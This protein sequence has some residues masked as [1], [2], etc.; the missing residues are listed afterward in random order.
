MHSCTQFNTSFEE[1]LNNVHKP[2][3]LVHEMRALFN[4]KKPEHKEDFSCTKFMKLSHGAQQILQQDNAGG[5]SVLSEVLSFEVLHRMFGAQF[6][7]GEMELQYFPMGS[8]RTDM[9]VRLNDTRVGVSVT[10][11]MNFVDD[12]Q[13]TEQD[14]AWILKK[15]LYGVT[16][17]TRNIVKKQQFK[18]QILHVW[19]RTHRVAQLLNKAYKKLKSE[20]RSNTIVLVTVAKNCE[21]V[22]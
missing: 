17:S 15:K 21:F 19:V 10:R 20:L 7:F 12:E 14:A 4:S 3:F 1:V 18:R 16:C 6:E 22:F 2:A 11:A 13:F 8:K 5:N 9:S